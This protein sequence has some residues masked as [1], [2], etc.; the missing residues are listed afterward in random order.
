MATPPAS[1]GVRLAT[2]ATRD[3][4]TAR[5]AAEPAA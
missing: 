5:Y 1:A 3:P 2:R 4:P